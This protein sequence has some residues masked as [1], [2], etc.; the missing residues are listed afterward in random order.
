LFEVRN[1]RAYTHGSRHTTS[2][3]NPICQT[4]IR[5]LDTAPAVDVCNA[6]VN[7]ASSRSLCNTHPPG[8]ALE[9]QELLRWSKGVMELAAGEGKWERVTLAVDNYEAMCLLPPAE[10]ATE[11]LMLL[12]N[13]DN[14]DTTQIGTQFVL[15]ALH[16]DPK[17]GSTPDGNV[18][19]GLSVLT[20]VLL[21]VIGVV[22]L[23]FY[24][25]CVALKHWRAN[26]H[27]S[28]GGRTRANGKYTN[29]AFE[30]TEGGD[31]VA[32]DHMVVAGAEIEDQDARELVKL[33]D[34]EFEG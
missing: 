7:D 26:K 2:P 10:G 18:G 8:N 30:E 23:G 17:V 29:V 31:G 12:V 14:G 16:L 9:K 6:L 3:L 25:V 11:D 1:F 13:D 5:G 33:T 20:L 22:L 24:M 19:E 4:Q 27:A 21:V 34:I 15:L 32:D 28:S